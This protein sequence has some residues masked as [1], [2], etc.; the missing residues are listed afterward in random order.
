MPPRGRKVAAAPGP[1]T[2]VEEGPS[3]MSNAAPGRALLVLLAA[4]ALESLPAARPARNVVLVPNLAGRILTVGGPIPAEPAGPTLMHEHLFIDAN[5]PYDEPERWRAA[6]EERPVTATR[7]GIYTHPLTLDILER[8]EMGFVNRDNLTLADERTAIEEAAAF[9]KLGGRIL[10]DVTSLG[11]KRDPPALRRVAEAT[12]LGIVMGTSWYCRPWHPPD[13][14]ARSVEELTDRIVRDVAVGAEGS[15]IRAGIIGEVGTQGGPLTGSE[16]T[17][18]RASGRASRL[19]GA[20][21]TLH[22]EPEAR[23]QPRMLDLLAAEGTDLTRVVIG[24]SNAIATD[25]PFLRRLLDRGACIE[26]DGLGRV[27]R[28]NGRNKVG[29]A[30]VGRAIVALIAAG[31]L[32]RILL[33]QDVATKIQLKA[34]GGGGYSFVLER[35]VP[36]LKR[37]GVTDAQVEAMLVRNPTRVLTFAAPRPARSGE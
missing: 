10:V 6:L 19:T 25:L 20:P 34:Y 3:P 1:E 16:I 27:P 33:A 21:V 2:I 23:E 11:L 15:G 18:I 7:L 29:D 37:I 31:Y 24:H 32:D 22:T 4:G 12:G 35:F 9:K 36:Y 26:F 5:L 28:I 17:V 13:L 14:E 30:Q 8:V